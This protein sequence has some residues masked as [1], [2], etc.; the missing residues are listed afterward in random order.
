MYTAPEPVG[1]NW[2]DAYHKRIGAALYY[3]RDLLD[4][5]WEYPDAEWKASVKHDV[6]ASDLRAAYDEFCST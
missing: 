6:K 3:L 2:S 4:R 1:V 5:E